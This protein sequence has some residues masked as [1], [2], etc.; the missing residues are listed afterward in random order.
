VFGSFISRYGYTRL[1]EHYET[2][3]I[4]HTGNVYEQVLYQEPNRLGYPLKMFRDEK[5][6]DEE[7]QI[8]RAFWKD[9]KAS[10]SPPA[11]KG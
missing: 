8:A 7:N 11:K 3:R 10:L 4:S 5:I 9:L 1:S 2:Q 6:A